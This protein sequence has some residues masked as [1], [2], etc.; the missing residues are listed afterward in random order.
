MPV[1]YSSLKESQTEN[2][3]YLDLSLSSTTFWQSLPSLLPFM[4]FFSFLGSIE[5]FLLFMPAVYWCY[6]RR[7]GM[8]LALI[9]IFSQGLNEILKVAFH[10]PRPYWVSPDIKVMSTYDNFG[11]PS[12]H[13]QDSVCVWGMLA[14]HVGRAW[15]FAAALMLILLIGLSRIYLNAHFPI[16]VIAGWAFGALIL[17]AFL[18]LDSPVSERLQRL[19]YGKQILVSFLASLCLPA[20]YAVAMA[21][22]GSWQVP[23]AWNANALAATGAAINP[24][25]PKGI[26]EASGM[27]FGIGLGYVLQ[28]RRGG[29]AA[30]GPL[31][32]R[33]LRY[34][35]GMV[36]LAFVW[37]GL[38]EVGHD[39]RSLVFYALS[40]LRALLAGAWVAG[41]APLAFVRL[42]LADAA[43]G[44]V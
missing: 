31:D 44:A 36:L 1:S 41:G 38:G 29:F 10:S 26:V 18:R 19:G 17:L 35:L 5:F 4:L 13:A 14:F 27:I 28:K 15:A 30:G 8:R 23:A 40:Y 6:D 22:L 34:A 21:S 3:M 33:L 32:K 16:D 12:G 39:R 20:L 37:Y 43:N 2:N 9:L 25:N 24:I 7:L 11:M 42:G